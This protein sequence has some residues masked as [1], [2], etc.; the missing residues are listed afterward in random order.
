MSRPDDDD[1]LLTPREV[2]Q[3]FGVRSTTIARW[4]REGR[5]SPLRT[6]GG[7]RRYPLTAVRRLLAAE[8]SRQAGREEIK[9]A[10]RLYDQGWNIRQVAEKFGMSYG[11]MRRALQ[12][13]TTLR[14]RG[15]GYRW[16]DSGTTFD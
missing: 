3:M 10:A 5:I 1:P 12:R 8:A 4:A 11:A 13:H 15:G 7:H 2:A 16:P 6:P 14:T 9:D